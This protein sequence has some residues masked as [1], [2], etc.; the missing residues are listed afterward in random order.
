MLK[1]VT[2]SRKAIKRQQRGAS[3]VEY[4]LM[5]IIFLSLMF[6]I[7]AF[8]HALFAY[9]AVNHLAKSG[10]RWAAVNGYTCPDDS[11]CNGTA[12]MNNGR[13][14]AGDI[15]TY[16]TSLLPSSMQ[17]S[18]LTVTP[19]W[20]APVGSPPVCTVAVPNPTGGANIGPYNNYP[21]C[22]VQVQV[23]YSYDFIFPLMPPQTV[24][25]S[26]TAQLIISH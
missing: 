24:N 6:G 5:L 1:F 8:G 20:V 13:A 3:L 14:S 25:M 2:T 9:Q 19:T 4:A 17:A 26:S 10:A 7:G 12:G 15:Q 22:T 23:Q 18:K 11:S 21:G 16:V